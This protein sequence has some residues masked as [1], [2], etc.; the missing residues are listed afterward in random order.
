MRDGRQRQPPAGRG[1]SRSAERVLL[2][3]L[4]H[5]FYWFDDALQAHL[6]RVAEISVP[7]AQSMMMVCIGEGI[8]SQA[9][10]ARTLRV[11]KQAVQ[12]GLKA[13]IAKGLVALAPDPH[14]RRKRRIVVTDRGFAVREVA[15]GGLRRLE[16]ELGRRLGAERLDRL[17]EA[18]AA[19]WGEP[20]LR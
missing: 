10:L 6:E 5:A 12:R 13:L 8:T 14:D 19:D 20:P 9:D 16:R 15:R 11:S 4:L 2:R 3:D 7:P 18:L 17:R 1:R